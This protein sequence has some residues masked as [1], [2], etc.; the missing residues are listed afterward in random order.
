[1][2]KTITEK[3]LITDWDRCC[4]EDENDAVEENTIIGPNLDLA[5]RDSI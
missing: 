1:M 3:Y 5:V 2:Y 4:E